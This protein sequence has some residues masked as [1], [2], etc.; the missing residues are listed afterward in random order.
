MK[1]LHCSLLLSLLLIAGCA[2]TGSQ[3][4]NTLNTMNATVPVAVAIACE[5]QPSLT[6]DFT[7]AA[8]II[9]LA[10]KTGTNADPALLLAD[11]RALHL[12][13][14]A[15]IAVEGGVLLYSAFVANGGLGTT[16]DA[17]TVLATLAFDIR[18]GLP[19]ATVSSVQGFKDGSRRKAKAAAPG[20]VTIKQRLFWSTVTITP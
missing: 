16:G 7:K 13:P 2:T 6:N 9:D 15:L 10:T 12:Q 3:L 11:I 8:A 17:N 5:A 14:R 19:P 20:T 1:K 4:Q 18:R